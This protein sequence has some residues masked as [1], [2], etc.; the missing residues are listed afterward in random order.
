MRTDYE[1]SGIPYDSPGVRIDRLEEALHVIN[2]AFGPGAFDFEGTHYR[3]TGYDGLP[4]P[5]QAK[6][7]LL[8]GGGAKRMLSVAARE[9][10]IVGING[11]LHD[12]VIGMGAIESM[13]AEAVDA[14][15]GWVRAAAGERVEALELNV[16]AFMVEVTDD[17]DGVIGGMA[18]LLGI[19][20]AVLSSRRSRWWARRSR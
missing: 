3:I 8:L 13:T 16:R 4:K 20:P 2:G 10:D 17:R 5:V 11:S 7:P 1:Q 12:G 15:V 18:E 9:A 14:K 19:E 6:P